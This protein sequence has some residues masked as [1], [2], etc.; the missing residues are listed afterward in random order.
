VNA[1]LEKEPK[2]AVLLRRKWF[3]SI[4]N[5]VRMFGM[6]VLFQKRT[7]SVSSARLQ[8]MVNLFSSF[9]EKN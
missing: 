4:Q 8:L 6:F 9:P 7:K 1:T 2:N 3:E 5:S